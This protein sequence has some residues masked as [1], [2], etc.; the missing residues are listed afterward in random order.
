MKTLNELRGLTEA[1][2]EGKLEAFDL[3]AVEKNANAFV[4]KVIGMDPKLKVSVNKSSNAL[5]IES[6]DLVK[7]VKPKMFKSLHL[8]PWTFNVQESGKLMLQLNYRYT[9]FDGGSNGFSVAD[10]WFDESGKIVNSRNELGS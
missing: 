1:S 6:A 10:M 4:K 7:G 5:D 9:H 3:K 8:V 2:N